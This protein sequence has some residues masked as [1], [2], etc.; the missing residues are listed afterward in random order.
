M[1]IPIQTFHISTS[2]LSCHLY[3]RGVNPLH[4]TFLNRFFFY[5]LKNSTNRTDILLSIFCI[6][7]CKS[8]CHLYNVEGYLRVLSTILHGCCHPLIPHF[9]MN[10]FLCVKKFHQ[11]DGHPGVD[12]PCFPIQFII[13]PLQ[14]WLLSCAHSMFPHGIF[15]MCKKISPEG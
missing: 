4:Y 1:D 9:H 10:F 12:F 14:Q 15:S 2:K 3:T 8:L 6:F 13:L 7:T 5:V 11:E